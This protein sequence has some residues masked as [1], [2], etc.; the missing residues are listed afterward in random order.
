MKE[1]NAQYEHG[2]VPNFDAIDDN[3][4]DE[5]VSKIG[6]AQKHRKAM[7]LAMSGSA[8]KMRNAGP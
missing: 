2:S 6:A 1:R 8:H 3:I 7:V 5:S 4:L